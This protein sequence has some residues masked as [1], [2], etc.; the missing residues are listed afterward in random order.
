VICQNKH[1]SNQSWLDGKVGNRHF[2][3]SLLV[4]KAPQIIGAS[5]LSLLKAVFRLGRSI[6]LDLPLGMSTASK[7]KDFDFGKKADGFLIEKERSKAKVADCKFTSRAI[8]F[9]ESCY[10]S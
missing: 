8:L 3:K 6:S 2:V 4:P 10:H 5:P 1:P 7:P 9:Y